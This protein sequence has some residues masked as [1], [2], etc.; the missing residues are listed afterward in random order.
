MEIEIFTLCDFAQDNNGKLIIIG[1]FD[2]IA[3][4][5]FPCVQPTCAVAGRI[6]FSEK[7]L[8][9]HS[10]RLRLIDGNGKELIQSIEGELQVNRS[11]AANH[12]T[13]NFVFNFGQLKFDKPGRYSFELYMDDEWKSGLPLILFNPQKAGV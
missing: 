9:A 11:N 5:Q 4:Q 1:T 12:S 8:G 6:R 10:F 2:T 3:A 7:E 13:I